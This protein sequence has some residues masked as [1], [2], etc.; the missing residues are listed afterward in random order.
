MD[1]MGSEKTKKLIRL[2]VWVFRKK[3]GKQA[4][5]YAIHEDMRVCANPVIRY[6]AMIVNK[7]A[8]EIKEEEYQRNTVRE[9]GELALWILNKDT[10][11]RP[12][13]FW[14]LDQILQNADALRE[15]LKPYIQE[16]DEWYV[17]TWSRT[18]KNSKE[19][20]KKKKITKYEMSPDEEIFTPHLQREKLKKIK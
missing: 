5:G 14:I 8:L 20:R 16:P 7:A 2:G 19:L 12:V 17:N 3:L 18:K 15:E 13:F 6:L 1:I 4:E 9:F 10:A 11:Y